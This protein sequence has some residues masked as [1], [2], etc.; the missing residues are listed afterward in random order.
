MKNR[1]EF[2]S[3]FVLCVSEW[4]GGMNERG[5]DIDMLKLLEE[6]WVEVGCKKSDLDYIEE[7]FEDDFNDKDCGWLYWEVKE[8]REWIKNKKGA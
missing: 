8:I 7:C 2:G 1:E 3:D 6:S 4:V 5:I